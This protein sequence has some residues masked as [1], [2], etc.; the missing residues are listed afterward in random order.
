TGV[1]D[2]KPE[3]V[4]LALEKGGIS[5]ENLTRALAIALADKDTAAIAE[6]LKKAGAVPP[7]DVK[8]ETLQSYAGKYKS[9]AL[10]ITISF[11]NGVLTGV[12]TGQRPQRLYAI[13]DVTFAPMFVEDIV[14]RFEVEG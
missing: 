7:P 5:K 11:A 8:P 4:K 6:E 13:D 12:V 3:F 9:D 1:S 2:G 14:V 10:E